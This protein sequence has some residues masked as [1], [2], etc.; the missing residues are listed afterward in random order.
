MKLAEVAVAV[1]VEAQAAVVALEALTPACSLHAEAQAAV[2]AL[3]ALAPACSLQ[4]DLG[5]VRHPSA[6]LALA[7]LRKRPHAE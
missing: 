5:A 1:A 6:V 2:V 7:I 4:A 3:E